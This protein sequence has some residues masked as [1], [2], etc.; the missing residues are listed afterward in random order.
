MSLSEASQSQVGCFL[1]SALQLSGG[2]CGRSVH[3]VMQLPDVFLQVK[4][5]AEALAAGVAGEGL[6]VIVRVHV[7]GQ[8]VDLVEGLV[9]D[10]ALVLLLSAVRQL[11]VLVVS[12]RIKKRNIIST[13][14]RGRDD[15]IHK[16]IDLN[17]TVAAVVTALLF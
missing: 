5:A 8:V 12:W 13:C 10:G 1:G 7:E 15:F 11:V 17:A 9:A 3:V 4:V 14:I 16:H 6:L 2:L